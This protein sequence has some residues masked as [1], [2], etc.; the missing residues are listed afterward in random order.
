[1]ILQKLIGKLF[2]VFIEIFLWIIPI[3]G[4]IASGILLSGWRSSFHFGYAILGLVIGLICDVIFFGP[5][6]ILLNIKASI[7]NIENK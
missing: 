7:K 4:F 6:V 3:V 1:M 2:S 5:I